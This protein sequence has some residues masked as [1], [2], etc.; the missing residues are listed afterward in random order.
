MPSFILIIF[1][2]TT[3]TFFIQVFVLTPL[4]LLHSF[5]LPGGIFLALLVLVLAWCFGG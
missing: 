4:A 1:L 5:N 2:L 3:G